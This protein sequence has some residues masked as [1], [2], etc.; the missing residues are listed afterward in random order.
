MINYIALF[1]I[2]NVWSVSHIS[3]LPTHAVKEKINFSTLSNQ[4][5]DRKVAK[6]TLERIDCG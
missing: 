1:I 5:R 3:P 2:E 4:D 6:A